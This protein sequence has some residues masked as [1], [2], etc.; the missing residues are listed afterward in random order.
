MSSSEP[1][2]AAEAAVP[3]IVTYAFEQLERPAGLIAGPADVLSAAWAEA[4]QVR[5][6]ARAAGEAEGRADGLAAA[7]EQAGPTLAALADAVRSFDELRAELVGVLEQEAAEL[8]L[9]LAEQIVAGAI[10][11]EGERILDVARGA[12]RRLAERNRVT[13]LVNPSDLEMLAA[14]VDQLQ[15][16]LGGIDHLD[17]QADRR[18]DRGGTIVRT[19]LAEID[20]TV[21]AQLQTARGIVAAALRGDDLAAGEADD[22]ERPA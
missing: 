4:E 13:I 12:L 14:S 9:R 16:E 6:Q 20:A 5:E 11:A 2:T 15:A 3:R 10:D 21:A 22:D 19:E 1:A 8:A 17:V 7:R 18:V